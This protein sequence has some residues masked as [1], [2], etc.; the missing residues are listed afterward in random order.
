MK[1]LYGIIGSPLGHSLSPLLH[2]WGFRRFGI[3]AEYQAWPTTPEEL[4]A[5]MVRFRETPLAGLSVTIPHKT[6]VMGY[7]RPKS[8]FNI[9]KQGEY[10]ERICFKEPK[11]I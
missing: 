7:Y 1:R 4:E 11:D 2:N 3:E 9:G 10:D 6:A 5:F 8:A